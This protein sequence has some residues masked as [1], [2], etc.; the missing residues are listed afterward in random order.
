[1]FDK[2]KPNKQKNLNNQNNEEMEKVISNK[3]VQNL[4][5]NEGIR[6]YQEYLP[7]NFDDN[8]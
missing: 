8:S 5:I 6:Y 7:S 3:L 2:S 4:E 1:M